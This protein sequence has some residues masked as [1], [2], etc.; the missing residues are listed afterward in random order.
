MIFVRITAQLLLKEVR[1]TVTVC[2][3]TDVHYLDVRSLLDPQ[4]QMLLPLSGADPLAGVTMTAALSRWSSLSWGLAWGGGLMVPETR[5]RFSTEGLRF[6]TATEAPIRQLTPDY[7]VAEAAGGYDV[8]TL[9]V[10]GVDVATTLLA[11][12]W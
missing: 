4:Q 10:H 7:W 9:A 2:E 11:R 5:I 3:A 6:R 1:L 12:N 8:A